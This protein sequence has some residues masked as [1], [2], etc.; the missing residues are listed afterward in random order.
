MRYGLLPA[1]LLLSACSAYSTV[2]DVPSGRRGGSLSVCA[3]RD[4]RL[5]PGYDFVVRRGSKEVARHRSQ[6]GAGLLLHDLKPGDYDIRLKGG[7][8]RLWAEARVFDGR[9]T[10]VTFHPQDGKDVWEFLERAVEIVGIVVGSVAVAAV[11]LYLEL[12]SD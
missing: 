9:L 11:L 8:L 3:L 6:D 4:E 5:A 1:V 12:V 10:R 2:D 7:G